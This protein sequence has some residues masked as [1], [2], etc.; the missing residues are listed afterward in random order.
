MGKKK[1]D[2]DLFD[3]KFESVEYVY[4]LNPR[5]AIGLERRRKSCEPG[6]WS[7]GPRPWSHDV[8]P[9]VDATADPSTPLSPD[10]YR[11]STTAGVRCFNKKFIFSIYMRTAIGI[12]L[13]I[14]FCADLHANDTLY[15]R[16]SDPYKTTKS[17]DG[18]YLRKTILVKDSGWIA[19][20]YNDSNRLV[21]RGYY[22]DTFFR[23]RNFTH[24]FYNEREHFCQ[25]VRSYKNG[26]PD[27][28]N[29]GLDDK[30]DT[31]WKQTFNAGKT[32]SSWT[33][34]GYGLKEITYIV[35]EEDADF[36][37]GLSRWSR[38]LSENFKYP[39][40]AIK[41]EIQGTVM[42]LFI[43]G[44]NGEV[45]GVQIIQSVHPLLDE[46]AMRLIKNAPRWTPAK[47][48]GM[49]VAQYKAQPVVFRL[50]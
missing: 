6:R 39:K 27:G 48:D 35:A 24:Y 45:S 26:K 21:A 4:V 13:F 1:A 44:S 40:P 32:V 29:I 31:L 46:E 2:A 9:R 49:K 36:P 19:F 42:V 14:L 23:T 16:L 10:G 28:L 18:K 47:W 37:G 11:D 25:L 17:A 30:G 43:V 33:R 3:G 7:K 22:T 20:D 34:P 12:I 38:Y 15:F 41:K 5:P 8:H 50:E